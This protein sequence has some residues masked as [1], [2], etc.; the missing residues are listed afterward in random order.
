[1]Q[2]QLGTWCLVSLIAMC[3]GG[4]A[5]AE[6]ATELEGASAFAQPAEGESEEIALGDVAWYEGWDGDVEIGL[7]GSEGNTEELDFRIAVNFEKDG[8]R[9]DFKWTN[10][11]NY[12]TEDSDETDNDFTSRFRADRKFEDSKW[13]AFGE[14]SFEFDEFESWDTRT[15][16]HAGPAYEFINND[17]Y[18]LL[19]RA[20]A[21]VFRETGSSRNEWVP[22]ALLGADFNWQVT[23]RQKLESSATYYPSLQDFSEFR[24][25]LI[26]GYSILVDPEVNM[27]LRIGIED[28]YESDPD[29]G[30]KRN[31]LDYYAVLVWSF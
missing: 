9:Y 26:A 15:S 31:D 6:D 2:K 24:F 19:G 20:G 22:E 10:V 14:G 27:T 7:N 29:E 28:E 18:F 3:S 23:E 8:P 4:M 12:G 11:Y 30:F 1:M 21:G 13:R 5:Q 25:L 17:K 16:I